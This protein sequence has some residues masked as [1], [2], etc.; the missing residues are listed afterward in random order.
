MELANIIQSIRR[1]FG[2]DDVIL[3]GHSMGG[4]VSRAYIQGMA[5]DSGQAVKDEQTGHFATGYR[6][7]VRAL[8]MLDTPNLGAMSAFIS[9]KFSGL[10]LC[11]AVDSTNLEELKTSSKLIEDLNT[12]FAKHLPLELYV[13][14]IVSY[15]RNYNQL[16]DIGCNGESD[17][18]VCKKEQNMTDAVG[19]RSPVWKWTDNPY[20]VEKDI[21]SSTCKEFLHRTHCLAGFPEWLGSHYRHAVR[22]VRAAVKEGLNTPPEGAIEPVQIKTGSGGTVLA[23]SGWA[24]DKEEKVAA[25][26]VNFQARDKATRQITDLNLSTSPSLPTSHLATQTG[27]P[28]WGSSG[29]SIEIPLAALAQQDDKE[30]EIIAIAYDNEGFFKAL[31]GRSTAFRVPG[32]SN[33]PPNIEIEQIVESGTGKLS[34]PVN[35]T[36]RVTGWAADEEDG[37]PVPEVRVFIDGQLFG[38]ATLGLP[39][40]SQRPA[41]ANSGWE[42]A[43]P[44]G[45]LAV[46]EHVVSAVAVDSQGRS[47]EYKQRSRGGTVFTVYAP[48]NT[49]PEGFI[50]LI[51]G[52]QD[53]STVLRGENVRIEGWAADAEDLAPLTKV[54]ILL[55]DKAVGNATLGKVR[56]DVAE[57]K[58]R[59]DWLNSGWVF[60]LSTSLLEYGSYRVKALAY[61]SKGSFTALKY[62]GLGDSTLTVSQTGNSPPEGYVEVIE[63]AGDGDRILAQSGVL[64]MRGWAADKEQGSP[65]TRVEIR[66][67]DQPFGTAAL[68]FA[69][70]QIATVFNRPAWSLSE[71]R[72]EQNIGMLGLGVHTVSAWALD[73][74]G[75][76]IKLPMAGGAP[77]TLEVVAVGNS[78]PTGYLDYAVDRADGDGTIPQNGRVVVAGWAADREDNS[79]VARVDVFIDGIKYGSANLAIARPDVAGVMGKPNWANSG[80]RGE[81]GIG[82]LGLGTH[83][84]TA[85]AFDSG[86]AATTLFRSAEL[87]VIAPSTTVLPILD[88]VHP[89][90]L[91]IGRRVVDL[92]GAN[93]QNGAKVRVVG[94][95]FI[96]DAPPVLFLTT[97]H[98]RATLDLLSPGTINIGVVNPDGNTSVARPLNVGVTAPVVSGVNPNPVPASGGDQAI[99]VI[100]NAFVS[101]SGLKV[102]ASYPGGFTDLT[103]AQ[104]VFNSPVQL[105]VILTVGLPPSPAAWSVQVFNPNGQA[106]NIFPFT[107]SGVPTPTISGVDP[108]TLTVGQQTSVTING[109]DF[110]TSIARLVITGPACAASS[111]CVVPNDV[112][113]T[114]MVNQLVG[115]VTLHNT[116]TF[117]LAVQN[118]SGALSNTFNLSVKAPF[119]AGISPSS[120]QVNVTD[121]RISGGGA[122][123]GGSVTAI[124]T[125]PN[126]NVTTFTVSADGNGNYLFGPFKLSQVGN[127]SAT[128]RDVATNASVFLTWTVT[129]AFTAT[130]SPSSGQAN[131]T[132]FR[133]TGGGAT[134]GGSVTATETFP[135]GSVTTFTVSAD[136]NG[137]YLF[138]PF[139]LAQV[140]NYSATIR[141]VSTNASVPLTWTVTP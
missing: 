141:N 68:G 6:R 129:A 132:D 80:W 41:W 104:V 135:N 94:S 54:S 123:P 114:K 73:D 67:N 7:D 44:I 60:D 81:F 87:E 64:R 33:R 66:I 70:S 119:T 17:G 65:V 137:N 40:P 134:P 56:I 95:N 34:V 97:G 106:S 61:D 76:S 136:G 100:G 53:T 69:R 102:R 72:F 8:I 3:V 22:Y 24:A 98:L 50:E 62:I 38:V 113:T 13:N 108:T 86:N 5:E 133:I 35:G 11:F 39:R 19:V 130:I 57:V 107:V 126:G 16:V 12:R 9:D 49:L 29:W 117:A 45:N 92:F 51:K 36:L 127:Y 140:G 55:N 37:A 138:G 122:T 21:L 63:D 85:V 88:S 20:D 28:G 32:T 121:F 139:K 112:L 82:N 105:T 83:T 115:P 109:N 96:S 75:S 59:P 74:K 110:N 31:P 101:G 103:G 10:P 2:V 128:L 84:V 46:G 79:P 93:F 26:R 131:V 52:P 58:D 18:I 15:V 47:T 89:N 118:G 116:G 1:Q 23:V 48:N 77:N 124:E 30:Y 43:R 25:A 99:N 78:P 14:S 71:W 42:I 90:S 120:G 111:P 4:L 27:I 91:L 125:F